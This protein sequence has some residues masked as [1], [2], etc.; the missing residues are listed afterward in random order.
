MRSI[1]TIFFAM[2]ILLVLSGCSKK[3]EAIS[4]PTP[5][6]VAAR[7]PAAVTPK[8]EQIVVEGI[9]FDLLD[10]HT[11]KHDI[12]IESY[13]EY[14]LEFSPNILTNKSEIEHAECQILDVPES[15]SLYQE[16]G[17]TQT[18]MVK[19][20]IRDDTA[21]PHDWDIAG[22]E[23]VYYLGAGRSPGLVRQ[24]L[25]E[26]MF[27][28]L[29]DNKSNFVANYSF[30]GIDSFKPQ[31]L[32]KQTPQIKLSAFRRVFLEHFTQFGGRQLGFW[33]GNQILG[34][35][36]DLSLWTWPI[37]ADETLL[38]LFLRKADASKALKHG[39][40]FYIA[41]C[42]MINIAEP[43]LEKFQVEQFATTLEAVKLHLENYEMTPVSEG[44][45]MPSGNTYSA[46]LT[47]DNNYQVSLFFEME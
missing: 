46:L 24:T 45:W 6:P 29:T 35:D 27:F 8:F 14:F 41:L 20:K 11:A 15:H 4:S 40:D 23:L 22:A 39:D 12:F 7:T 31:T 44:F 30:C 3:N 25:Q 2:S 19:I 18:I 26:H 17:W 42:A 21:L 32:R 1:K 28:G 9:A 5:S 34:I 10:D 37:E 16:A 33:A 38:S 36:D 13:L 43:Y 47:A